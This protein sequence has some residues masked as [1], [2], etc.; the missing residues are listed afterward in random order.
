MTGDDSLLPFQLD[1]A[2]MRGRVVRLDATL[3]RILTQHRYPPAVS[4]LVAEAAI[5]TALIGSTMKLRWR[6]SL[7]IRGEGA[8]HLI[9]TDYFAP[10]REGEPGRLRAYAGFDKGEVVSSR[11]TPFALLG[12]GV[13]GVTI[14]QG[15]GMAPYQGIT[16]LT[17]S[18]LGDCA[19]AYFAQSEQIAT[20]FTTLSGHAQ[21][22]GE[23][24]RW[25]GGGIMLQQLGAAGEAVIADAPSGQDG[26]MTADDIAAMNA[27]EEDWTRVNMLLATVDPHELIGPH[28]AIEGLLT[29]LFHEEAPRVYPALP[30]QFGCTCS[31]D[32]VR[33]AMAQYSAKDI[34]QMTD[35]R[36][37]LTA[38]CQFCSAHYEF[39]PATL[40]FEANAAG[41]G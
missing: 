5:L 12:R 6:F 13:L 36:G 28:L 37:K 11:Q 30:V 14:D 3:D 39:D 34:A 2:Q 24:M 40:G 27:S 18:T 23:E 20:R 17:G 32:R 10:S 26:L 4:A 41:E 35:E 25:R 29:R 22:P 1:R 16:P 21:A 19:E 9:A 33:A 38:D 31:A 15:P 8:V 7:Q